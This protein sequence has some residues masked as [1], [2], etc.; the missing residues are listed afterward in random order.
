M[1][2]IKN[3]GTKDYINVYKDMI[4][5]SRHF[6]STQKSEIWKLEHFPIF[7]QG[8]YNG[9]THKQL[10]SDSNFP[11]GCP[12]II[13]DRG[14]GITYHGPG[15][16]IVYFMLNLKIIKI[17][18]RKLIE[19]IEDSGITLLRSYGINASK[20]EEYPGVY[21]DNKKILSIGLRVK[22]NITYHGISI[23]VNMNLNPFSYIDPCGQKALKM[24]QISDFCPKIRV[25]KVL[26]KYVSVFTKNI[27]IFFKTHLV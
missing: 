2:L 1:F 3:L 25:K 26:D 19:V 27:K 22:K 18:A 21:V 17:G 20:I 24:T 6:S 10:Q 15:Q 23:N 7:T 9:S 5:L 16:G 4:D 14:G 12:V 8:K 13:T 11:L